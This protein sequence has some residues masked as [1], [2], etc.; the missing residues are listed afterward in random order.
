MDSDQLDRSVSEWINFNSFTARLLDAG[1]YQAYNF[2]VWALRD[3]LEESTPAQDLW[4]CQ[5]R[6]AAEWIRQSGQALFDLLSDADLDEDH[7]RRTAAGRL[8]KGKAGLCLERWQ[9]WKERFGEV[10]RRGDVELG[11]WALEVVS[12]MEAIEQKVKAPV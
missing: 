7:A 12:R 10:P 8:Y 2:A 5:V 4:A 9:F 3:A 1:L 11:K 6:A